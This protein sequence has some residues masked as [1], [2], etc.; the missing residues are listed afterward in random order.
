M[1]FVRSLA[2]EVLLSI[3]SQV[4]VECNFALT[5]GLGNCHKLI[6]SCSG[7]I[8]S[9]YHQNITAW[10]VSKYGV[11]SGSY[12]PVFWLNAGK[13][14]PKITRYVD[15]FHAVTSYSQRL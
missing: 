7:A 15:T 2:G 6:P 9:T 1:K 12:F 8:L 3:S 14:G 5:T 10:K 11:M 13:Y 4:R